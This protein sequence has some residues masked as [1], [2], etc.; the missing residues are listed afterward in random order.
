MR[1]YDRKLCRSDLRKIILVAAALISVAAVPAMAQRW[2]MFR[3]AMPGMGSMPRHHLAM[4]WG[5]PAPYNGLTNPLPRTNATVDQGAK[6]YVRNCVSCHGAT[7]QGDGEAGRGLSPP[8]G[9]LAWLSQMP[10]SQWD[11]F[12][13]WTIAEGGVSFGTAMPTF[14]QNLSKE[15]I[16]AV[17][18]YVQ[19]QLPQKAQ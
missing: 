5:I 9:N 2:P 10:I 12:M 14:K 3:G 19:A 16:W 13:Y 1:A 18:A 8:P 4:M 11:A 7:G 17:I 6:V 15:D